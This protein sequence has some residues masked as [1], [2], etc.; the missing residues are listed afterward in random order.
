MVGSTVAFTLAYH[1]PRELAEY[2]A[3]NVMSL[4]TARIQEFLLRTSLLQRLSA[5][6]CEAVTGFDDAQSLLEQLERS[7][8]FVRALDS[9]TRWFKYHGLF[10]SYLVDSLAGLLT[11]WR[12]GCAVARCA[13]WRLLAAP[14]CPA[15]GMAVVLVVAA[16]SAERVPMARLSWPKR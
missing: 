12:A 1:G 15:A 5:P 4:Q 9:D 2:L 11:C 7:G 10:S 3:D 13:A 14:A 8:L 6:L 16:H